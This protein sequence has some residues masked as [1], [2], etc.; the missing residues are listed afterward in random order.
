M[1]TTESHSWDDYHFMNL[2]T[3]FSSFFSSLFFS[4]P[5]AAVVVAVAEVEAAGSS[6]F[7][8][9]GLLKSAFRLLIPFFFD[10]DFAFV[11]E[12]DFSSTESCEAGS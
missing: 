3:D 6:F 12:T 1:D 7:V 4:S 11:G 10:F 5:A 2:P 8:F 9:F